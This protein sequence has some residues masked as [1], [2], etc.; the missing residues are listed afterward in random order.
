M[1]KAREVRRVTTTAP[2][3]RDWIAPARIR[4]DRI[5]AWREQM[6]RTLE[7]HGWTVAR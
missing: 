7:A 2:E 3:K 6:T 5:P 4:N 1:T